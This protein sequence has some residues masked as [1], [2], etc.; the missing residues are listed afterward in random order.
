MGL[1]GSGK[2]YLAEKLAPVIDAVHLN[3]DK[4][5]SEHDDWDFSEEGR[6]RQS[7]RMKDLS[8]KLLQ[9]GNHVV[10]DFVCPTE[11]T[12]KIFNPDITIW[13]DTVE[14]GRFEDTNKIFEK[15]KKYDFRINEKTD[16]DFWPTYLSK[17]ILETKWDSKYPTVQ[18]LGRWQPWHEGHR[19]LFDRAISKTGQVCLMVRD[20]HGVGDNPFDHQNVSKRI[21]ENL[22]DM[23]EEGVDY[24]INHVPNITHITYG[25]SV[26]YTLAQEH[27]G[28][29]IEQISG[30]QK[31]RE[32]REKGEL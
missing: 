13:V 31:R 1:P 14:E 30:T 18:L 15:P 23:Y 16:G 28:K 5:R 29:E 11:E 20:C 26:G 21:K 6:K 2:T 7:G 3:A 32:L 10:V 24:V 9:E 17:R 4:V 27:L 8:E 25:R 12:R 22:L 19:A